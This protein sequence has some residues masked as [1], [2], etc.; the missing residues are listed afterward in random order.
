MAIA[1]GF[2]PDSIN[3]APCDETYKCAYSKPPF[4]PISLYSRSSGKRSGNRKDL[5]RHFS[6]Q[7]VTPAFPPCNGEI[8]KKGLKHEFPVTFSE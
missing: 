6:C 4:S 7:Y 5:L 1:I 2:A 3:P 8:N